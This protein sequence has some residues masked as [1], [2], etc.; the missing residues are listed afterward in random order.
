MVR[1][2]RKGLVLAKTETT[3]GTDPTPTS[4][5]N[6]ILTMDIELKDSFEPVERDV[7]IASLTRKQT[8][9]VKRFTE[10]KFTAELYGSGS[11]ALPPRTGVLFKACSMAETINSGTSVVYTPTSSSQSSCTLW[12][13]I[14]GVRH[15]ITG[16]VG[17]WKLTGEAGKQAFIEFTMTGVYN[18]PTDQSFPTPTFESTV[19]SVPTI[20]SAGLTLNS[21]ALVVNEFTV[22]MGN[23]VAPRPSVNAAFAI[24]GFQ[25][26]DRKPVATIDPEAELL[27]V[28]NYRSD[29]LST[30]RNLHFNIGSTVGNKVLINIPKYNVTDIA[31]SDRDQ[32]LVENITGQCSDGGSG[33]DE[34]SL[35][36]T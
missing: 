23:T 12:V 15:I 36:F 33:D 27:A 16:A 13:Y 29:I 21:V 34:L 14:D 35:V 28:Y 26:T 25:V 8:V 32:T 7:Q 22:D 1:L 2:K 18:A 5:A 20:K 17:T 3:Y 31:Y 30:P 10:V 6:A 11:V 9:G 4:S 24:V 19:D